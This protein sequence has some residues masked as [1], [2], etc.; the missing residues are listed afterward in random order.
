MQS[1]LRT[2]GLSLEATA[3]L[4]ST[5]EDFHR[6]FPGTMAALARART[7]TTIPGLDLAEGT[8]HPGVGVSMAALSGRLAATRICEDLG[9]TG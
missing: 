6:A 8:V 3:A 7:A 9:S 5:P 1:A 4:Q 2:V